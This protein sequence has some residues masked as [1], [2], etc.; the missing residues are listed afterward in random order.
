[1]DRLPDRIVS[2][3][4]PELALRRLL[5]DAGLPEPVA[6]YEVLANGSTYRLDLAYPSAMLAL[7]YDGFDAHS[8][9]DRFVDDRRRQNDLVDAGWTIRRFTHADLRDR[10]EAVVSG[11]R[12]HLSRS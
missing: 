9:V 6:Q 2:E 7:E 1:M 5:L 12:R 4:G 3:S 10:P 8:G 11:V